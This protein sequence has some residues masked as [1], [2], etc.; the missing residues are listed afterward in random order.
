[1]SYCTIDVLLNVFIDHHFQNKGITERLSLER[2][3]KK[4]TDRSTATEIIQKPHQE[5][6]IGYAT[7]ESL[8]DEEI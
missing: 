4:N 6:A 5:F 1:M 7:L 2:I 3:E 8:C